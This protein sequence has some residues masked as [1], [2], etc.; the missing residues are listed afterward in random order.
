[1]SGSA[2]RPTRRDTPEVTTGTGTVKWFDAAKGF[3]FV[4]PAEGNERNLFVHVN[5]VRKAGLAETLAVG[6]TVSYSLSIT[7]GRSVI[8]EIA[9]V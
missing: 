3:G 1:M 9:R 6:D 5:T 8:T 2:V 7:R 4:T